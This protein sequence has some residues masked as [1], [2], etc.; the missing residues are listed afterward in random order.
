MSAS[1]T[2]CISKQTFELFKK[3]TREFR[4]ELLEIARLDDN[5]EMAYQYTFNLFPLSKEVNND[6]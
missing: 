4:K 1:T 5:P 3:R 2:F 6:L